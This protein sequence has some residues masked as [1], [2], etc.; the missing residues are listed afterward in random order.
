M[1]TTVK[2]RL[3]SFLKSETVSQRAFEIKV[4][5][6]N[7]YVNNIRVSIQPDKVQ[8][9]A[10]SYPQLN[11]GWLLT[12]E[13]E[14]LKS[15]DKEPAQPYACRECKKKDEEIKK[16]MNK[17]AELSDDYRSLIKELKDKKVS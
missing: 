3:I 12:G 13:G 15:G 5:L 16:W 1:K 10:L 11:T 17:Y 14:M 2:E 4:G 8:K 6:S 7:G 9:I